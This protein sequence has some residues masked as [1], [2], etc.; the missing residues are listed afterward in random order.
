MKIVDLTLEITSDTITFPGYPM[1]NLIKW[2]KFDTQGYVSEV[3]F[4]ST[5]T[6]THMDAPFHFNPNGQTIDQVEVK[7]YICNNAI[8]IKIQKNANEMI[9]GDDIIRNS[10]YEIK[11]KDTVVF[12]TGWE[13][14]IKQKDNYLKNNPGLSKDAVEYFVE[15]KV[16]AVAIDCPSIDIGTDSGFIAHK[17]LLSNEILVI[18]NLCNLYRFNNEKFTLLITPLKL[19]GASGSPIRAIGIEE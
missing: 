15:K 16:N 3:M 11:E 19:A 1:P 5:H 6:G 7:R 17:M 8:L 10:K 13:R 4:L 14:Q 9:T 2:S 18:E 12:S